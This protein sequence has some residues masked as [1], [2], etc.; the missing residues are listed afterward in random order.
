MKKSIYL[1]LLILVSLTAIFTYMFL[2]KQVKF[3][4]TNY[5]NLV[6]RNTQVKDSLLVK[7]SDAD[8]FSLET[9]ENAQNYF[10]NNPTK[11][12]LSYDKLIPMIKDKLLDFNTHP[13]GNPYTGNDMINGKKFIINKV[14]VLNHRWI[15]AD[16]N[17]GQIWGEAIIKY[18]VNQDGSISYEAA[19]SLLYSNQ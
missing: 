4:Q 1:Y 5:D 10:E 8:Y 7:L 17:N 6:K 15:I 18:F 16:F 12:S 13:N 11:Q 19:E 2:S 9:N 14:K 3:E